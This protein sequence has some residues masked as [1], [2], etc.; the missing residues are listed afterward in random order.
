MP[1][2]TYTATFPDGAVLTRGSHREYAAAWRVTYEKMTPAED[3]YSRPLGYIG[4]EHGF[5]G[6]DALARSAASSAANRFRGNPRWKLLAEEVATTVK[7]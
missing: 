5:S 4:S 2:T 7:A 6:T 3:Q 1:K